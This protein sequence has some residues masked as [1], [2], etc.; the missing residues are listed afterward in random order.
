MRSNLTLCIL[1]Q[2][3]NFTAIMLRPTAAYCQREKNRRTRFIFRRPLAENLF[4]G[5]Q[6]SLLEL[7][8]SK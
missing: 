8:S 7:V 3:G 6:I 1:Y 4:K 2:E 5:Q